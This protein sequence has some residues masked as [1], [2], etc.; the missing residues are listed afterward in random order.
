MYQFVFAL[1]TMLFEAK[2]EWIVATQ[3]NCPALQVDTYQEMLLENAKFLSLNGGRGIFYIFQGTL[4][5]A[6]ASLTDIFALAIGLFLVFFGIIHILMYKG[7]MPQEVAA[8]MREGYEA[9]RTGGSS[10]GH[11]P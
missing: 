2:P 1:T 3:K 5:L 9:V 7:V 4:W 10:S 11:D 6:F 8:K